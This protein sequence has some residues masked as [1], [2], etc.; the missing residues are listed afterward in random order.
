MG[1]VTVNLLKTYIYLQFFAPP[2]LSYISA[3]VP[4]VTLYITQLRQRVCGPVDINV[5][6][7]NAMMYSRLRKVA[8]PI[9]TTKFLQ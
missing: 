8:T 3:G 2:L 9:Y 7:E 1:D 6:S 5:R 4:V